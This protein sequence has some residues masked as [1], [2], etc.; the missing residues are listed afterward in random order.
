MVIENLS[1]VVIIDFIALL[2]II[3]AVI[4]S[5]Y[6]LFKDHYLHLISF[7]LMWI[8]LLLYVLF[9][10]LSDL[11]NS[12]ELHIVC[13]YSLILLGFAIILFIDSITIGKIDPIKILLMT[14]ASTTTIIF[15]FDPNAIIINTNGAIAYP[16]F[17]GRF[18]IASLFQSSFAILLF[19]YGNF[20][21]VLSSPKILRRSSFIYFLASC[22]FGLGPLTVQLF[23]IED[24][25]P[26]IANACIAI[27]T[28]IATFI[29]IKHP[30]IAFILPFKTYRLQ[31]IDT[32]NGMPIFTYKWNI[33]ENDF[34]ETIFS[35]LIKAMCTVFETTIHKGDIKEIHL[36]HAIIYLEFAKFQPIVAVLISNKPSASLKRALKAFSL[37]LFLS[38]FKDYKFSEQLDDFKDIQ[39]IVEKYFSFVPSHQI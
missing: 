20:S 31:I 23:K 19:L 26:G 3:L 7:S 35:G 32:K 27:G 28:L 5:I 25:L 18:R 14:I 1:L 21:I 6:H 38:R 33:I 8:S 15:S 10:A 39:T 4:L 34:S 9:Q 36:E 30:K 13:F 16:T 24:D 17:N 37:K 2:P 29:I 11:F 22:L 12:K